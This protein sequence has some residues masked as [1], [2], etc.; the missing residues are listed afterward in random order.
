MQSPEKI[1][2]EV[3]VETLDDAIAASRGGADRLELC[4]ALEVGGQTSSASIL[5]TIREYV[6]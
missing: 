2:L 1:L 6:P 5:K 3:P 4:A